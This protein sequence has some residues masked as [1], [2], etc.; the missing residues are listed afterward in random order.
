MVDKVDKDYY[1][2]LGVSSDA[3]SNDIK[4]AYKRLALDNHPDKLKLPIPRKFQKTKNIYEINE[5]YRV[6]RDDALRKEYD[7]SRKTAVPSSVNMNMLMH[8]FQY[9]SIMMIH[10]L[11][12]RACPAST[13]PH[14][15]HPSHIT[16]QVDVTLQDLYLKRVK[17]LVVNVRRNQVIEKQVLYLSLYNYQKQYVF[18]SVGDESDDGYIRGDIIVNLHIVDHETFRI[19]DKYNIWTDRNISLYQY[20]YGGIIHMEYFN[21]E[22]ITVDV[23][24]HG[25]SKTT[26]MAHVLPGKGIPYYDEAHEEEK[27]GDLYVALCLALPE[28]S[29][30]DKND[31]NLKDIIANKF[32][33]T[34]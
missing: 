34:K 18:A 27:Y 7:Y 23:H 33:R 11:R 32:Q 1:A 26:T 28:F 17:K 12:A 22:T 10:F 24:G 31:V 9:L 6:L 21:G 4:T 30:D 14:T 8:Y 5:A 15:I 25:L 16:L 13:T 3:S 20:Y 29:E 19:V 2:V